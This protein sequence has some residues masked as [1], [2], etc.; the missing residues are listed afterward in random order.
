MEVMETD[1]PCVIVRGAEY[2]EPSTERKPWQ[3][4]GRGG[5]TFAWLSTFE[6][7]AGTNIR[8]WLWCRDHRWYVSEAAAPRSV[9]GGAIWIP[10]D[11]VLTKRGRHVVA[12]ADT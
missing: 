2:A 4:G 6:A 7:L 5:E 10:L 8:Y 11:D 1:P 9:A 3:G 12:L